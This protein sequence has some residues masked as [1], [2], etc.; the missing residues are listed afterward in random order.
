MCF[1]F[2]MKQRAIE[3]LKRYKFMILLFLMSGTAFLT[4]IGFYFSATYYGSLAMLV[5]I[6]AAIALSVDGLSGDTKQFR[7]PFI[8]AAPLII[9][10]ALS[11]FV[12]IAAL[13]S[14]TFSYYE[15]SLGLGFCFAI[16]GLVYGMEF[17][18]EVRDQK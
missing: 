10:A 15:F 6:V 1:Y 18:Y 14:N 11:L 12:S 16:I 4:A 13:L 2:N 9:L 7:V 3:L 5:Y 17:S 8:L